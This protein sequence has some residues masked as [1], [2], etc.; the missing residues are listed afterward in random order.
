MTELFTIIF[1]DTKEVLTPESFKAYWPNY[2]SSGSGLQGW[3]PPK[4]IYYTLG[5][6]RSGFSHIPEKLKPKLAIA[7]F[8]FTE[9]VE[10]GAEL[11]ERQEAN[12]IKKED[13]RE[14]L[15]AQRQLQ[16][17]ERDV[18]RANERLKQLRR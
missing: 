17:A 4:K 14:K 1:K 10:T 12:R 2:G 5:T 13:A 9:I 6:A 7:K 15:S 3:R 8:A 16:A 18:I 11:Q